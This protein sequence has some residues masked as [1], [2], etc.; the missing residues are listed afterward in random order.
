[1]NRRILRWVLYA[2]GYVAVVA[3]AIVLP[4]RLLAPLRSAGEPVPGPTISPDPAEPQMFIPPTYREGH[5]VVMPVK[6]PDGSTAE[7]LRT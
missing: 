2:V 5:R 1:V 6:F 7:L 4:L 3:G